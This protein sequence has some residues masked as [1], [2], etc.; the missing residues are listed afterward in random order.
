MI[1]ADEIF[2]YFLQYMYW[3]GAGNLFGSLSTGKGRSGNVC[4]N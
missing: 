3:I 2:I 4:T 1:V